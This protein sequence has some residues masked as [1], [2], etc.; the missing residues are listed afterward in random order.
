MRVFRRNLDLS[1]ATPR[2]AAPDDLTT[3]SRLFCNSAHRFLG[4]PTGDLSVLLTSAPAMLLVAGGEVLAAAIGG[5]RSEGTTWLRGLAL[6]D[7]LPTGAVLDRLLP[8]FHAL[9]R[10]ESLRTLF[11]AGDEAADIWIQPALTARGYVRDT[12]VVVYEKSGM[13]VPSRGNQAVRVRRAQAVDLETILAIDRSCFDPQWNKD[14]GILGPAI[15]ETPYFVVAELDGVL[16]GYA[17]ATTHFDGRLVHLVRIAVLPAIQGQQVGVRLLAEVIEF[18]HARGAD[19]LTLN[20][21]VHNSGAQRL[22][23]WFGFRR[24]GEQQTVLRFDL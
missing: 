24:T 16:V 8:P 20:T 2:E 11:Y 3:I 18:A 22:Y 17:F 5:W 13:D 7:G 9:L 19:L 12:D 21:Q 1:Q 14:E 4:F 15:F 6:A 23:E 10:A